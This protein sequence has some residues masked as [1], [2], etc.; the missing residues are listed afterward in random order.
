MHIILSVLSCCYS[1]IAEVPMDALCDVT[2]TFDAASVK[3][4]YGSAP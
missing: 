1:V 3:V 2:D 4:F